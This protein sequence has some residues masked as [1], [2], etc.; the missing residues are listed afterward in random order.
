[1]PLE[2]RLRKFVELLLREGIRLKEER[3]AAAE[4]ERR[5]AEERQIRRE[6]ERRC[7]IEL[8]RRQRMER[9]A[10]R[11]RRAQELRAFIAAVLQSRAGSE[12]PHARGLD[13][14]L[15]WARRYTDELD[16]L[17]TNPAR[18]LLGVSDEEAD[19]EDVRAT[20]SRLRHELERLSPGLHTQSSSPFRFW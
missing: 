10:D 3:L 14:W 6:E 11:W 9:L 1:M 17:G 13:R 2:A 19:D 8:R 16:P 7:R 5:E 18:H 4:R 15:E 12:E 20:V